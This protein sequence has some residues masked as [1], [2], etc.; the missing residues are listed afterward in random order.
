[1]CDDLFGKYLPDKAVDLMD[2]A[3]AAARI[4]AEK[5]DE[6]KPVDPEDIARVVARAR[7]VPAAREKE[8]ERLK[9]LEAR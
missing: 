7:R 2:E 9:N 8:R 4:R 6:G 5:A 1:M 3:C